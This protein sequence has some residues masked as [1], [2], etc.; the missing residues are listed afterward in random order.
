MG[1]LGRNQRYEKMKLKIGRDQF[2]KSERLS[3]MESDENYL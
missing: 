3:I 2:K 1:N